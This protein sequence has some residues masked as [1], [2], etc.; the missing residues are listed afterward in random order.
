MQRTSLRFLFLLLLLLQLWGAA[1]CWTKVKDPYKVLGVTNKVTDSELKKAYRKLALQFHPDKNPEGQDEFM[2]IQRAYATLSDEKLRR[3]YDNGGAWDGDDAENAGQHQEQH[4]RMLG[5]S[6]QQQQPYVGV[7]CSL[8]WVPYAAAGS[9]SLMSVSNSSYHDCYQSHYQ[10]PFEEESSYHDYY[11]SHYQPPFEEE[12][13]VSTHNIVWDTA[14]ILTLGA[15]AYLAWTIMYK[16]ERIDRWCELVLTKTPSKAALLAEQRALELR[17]KEEAMRR[18]RKQAEKRK[19]AEQAGEEAAQ[20]KVAEKARKKAEEAKAERDAQRKRLKAERQRLRSMCEAGGKG[21]DGALL[22]QAL[23]D[24]SQLDRLC[25]SLDAD[26]LSSL[27]GGDGALLQQALSNPSQ[28]DRLCNSLDAD[29]LSSLCQ[30]MESCLANGRR[31]ELAFAKL[32]ELDMQDAM[33]GR[34]KAAEKRKMEEALGGLK[35]H[36]A[37]KALATKWSEEELQKLTKPWHVN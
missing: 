13:H 23:L 6:R 35:G 16:P 9:S 17:E 11:Q 22:Q 1:D 18:A 2:Q 30:A 33:G 14:I 3:Q 37:S 21:G 28:L 36:K 29:A 4:Y 15:L 5:S 10:P 8:M 26:A 20:K 32:D 31:K 19:A 12:V 24:P 25:I 34:Q 27:K 7:I